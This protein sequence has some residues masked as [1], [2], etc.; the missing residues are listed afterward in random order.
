M[1][2]DFCA[3]RARGEVSSQQDLVL[4]SAF[5]PVAPAIARYGLIKQASDQPGHD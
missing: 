1:K 5:H 3:T 2:R 4:K